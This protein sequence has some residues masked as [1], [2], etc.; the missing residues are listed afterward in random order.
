[1][2]RNAGEL[3]AHVEHCHVSVYLSGDLGAARV[4]PRALISMWLLY[5]ADIIRWI[6]MALPEISYQ[7]IFYA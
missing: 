4:A 7:A 3:R 6:P 2:S 5:Y 1:M